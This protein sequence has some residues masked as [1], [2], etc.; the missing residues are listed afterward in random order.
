MRYNTKKSMDIDAN[1]L[2]MARTIIRAVY[3]FVMT[4]KLAKM[5]DAHG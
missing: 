3:S 5:D 1:H 2:M 4:T